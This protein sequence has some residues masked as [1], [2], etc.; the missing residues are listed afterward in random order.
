MGGDIAVAPAPGHGSVF[1]FALMLQAAPD[2]ASRAH[3]TALAGRRLLLLAPDDGEAPVL[4]EMLRTEGATVRLVTSLAEAAGL[5]GA[6]AA[7]GER[8]DAV[9]IDARAA[10][11]AV[12]ALATLREAAGFA[13]PAA[14]VIE[15]S[16]RATVGALSAAGFDAYLVKPVRRSSLVKVTAAIAGGR[17][18]SF[19]IDPGDEPVARPTAAPR[20]LA[21]FEVLLAE[22]NEINALLARAVLERMGHTVTEVRDGNAAVAAVRARPGAYRA[23]LMDLHMPGLDGIAAARAIRTLE[24]T[25]GLP[26]AAIIAVTA[27]ALADTRVEAEGAGIDRVVE[28]PVT[29]ERLRQALVDLSS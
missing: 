4:A 13:M 26:R 14:A 3:A 18:E 21:G 22:D 28:K 24:Q 6:A 5:A 1:S 17:P 25:A 11:D 16:R 2:A 9:V 10:P 8:H 7:A 27:D 29:P 23:I 15:P 20:R 19:R 12:S